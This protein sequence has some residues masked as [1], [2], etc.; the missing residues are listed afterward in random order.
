MHTSLSKDP[1]SVVEGGDNVST[2]NKHHELL[3][4]ERMQGE[5]DVHTGAPKLR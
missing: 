1:P 2:L 3:R 4:T 5:G